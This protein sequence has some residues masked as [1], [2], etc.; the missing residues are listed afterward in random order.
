[1]PVKINGTT[2]GSVTLAAPDTGSDVTLTLPTTALATESFVSSSYLPIAG[3]KILQVVQGTYST[4]VSTTSSTPV[5]VGVSATITPSST[6]S[7]ILVMTSV[8]FLGEDTS[9]L[10]GRVLRGS[11]IIVGPSRINRY[12]QM[13][14]WNTMYLDSPATTTATTY[15]PQVY[16]DVSGG[17]GFICQWNNQQISTVTLFE[18]SA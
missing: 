14:E 18:V 1:M 12:V 6:T 17:V 7:K 8:K 13:G 3:G 16:K 4:Q 10:W 2:S 11:T 9:L 15:K 5:D